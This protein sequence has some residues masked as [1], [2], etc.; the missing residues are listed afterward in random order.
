MEASSHSRAGCL[1]GWAGTPMTDVTTI[2]PTFNAPN[3]LDLCLKS[4]TENN[5]DTDANP[6][7]VVV[8]G[9]ESMRLN[10]DILEKYADDIVVLDLPEHKGLSIA[11][12]LGVAAAETEYV[13]L[14]NDDNLVGKEY[15]TRVL[16]EMDKA[17]AL[18]GI[19]TILTL[20]QVEMQPSIYHFGIQE[21]G[22]ITEF[23]YL[24]WLAYEHATKEDKFLM[25]GCIFPA[26]FKKKYYMAVG[27]MDSETYASPHVVDQDTFLKWELLGFKF[28][29]SYN[30][31]FFHFGGAST[32]Q[33]PDAAKYYKMEHDALQVYHEKWGCRYSC[34]PKTN[35]KLPRDGLFR[36]FTV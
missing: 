13:L 20:Q 1:G 31:S 17:E 30:M 34:E 33:T 21:F 26:I 29:R 35:S 22:N 9:P 23:D 36:G 27:G 10:I 24:K 28:P 25:T 32:K 2:I 6:I 8:D 19:R 18:F 16:Q 11:L 7:M 3:Y 12:N 4:A 14:L 15:D 5:T